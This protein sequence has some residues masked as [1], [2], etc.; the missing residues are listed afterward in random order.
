LCL[1]ADLKT[2]EGWRRLLQINLLPLA[3]IAFCGALAAFRHALSQER[4]DY[5]LSL[6]SPQNFLAALQSDGQQVCRSGA[7]EVLRR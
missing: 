7:G 2:R 4:V 1:L 5:V 3:G 6:V